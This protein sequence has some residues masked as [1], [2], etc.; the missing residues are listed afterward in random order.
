MWFYKI[1]KTEDPTVSEEQLNGLGKAGWEL[2]TILNWNGE[3]YYYLKQP[4][5]SG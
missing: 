1:L 2:V 3:W 4:R 5:L